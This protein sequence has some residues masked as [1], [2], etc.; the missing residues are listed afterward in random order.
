MNLLGLNDIIFANVSR[1]PDGNHVRYT[2][3]DAFDY[4][5][6]LIS[7]FFESKLATFRHF[8]WQIQVAF[9]LIVVCI[10][11]IAVVAW[12][13]FCHKKRLKQ[14]HEDL[15]FVNTHLRE[16][17][18]NILISPDDYDLEMVE[19][20]C[21]M[22]IE[23]ILKIPSEVLATVISELRLQ[24][25]EVT[26]LPNLDRLCEITG[27]K[28]FY[29]RNLVE[30]RDVLTTLQN[31]VTMTIRISEGHLAT[32]INH[33][34]TNI[35]HMARMC[36]IVCTKAEPYRYLEEDLQEKQALWR[37]MML[38]RLFGWLKDTNRQM[39]QFL[40]LASIINDDATA[41][42][43]IEEIAYWGNEKEKV[44]ISEF[45]LSPKFKC[46]EAALKVVTFLH[47]D[48]QEDAII[49]SYSDQPEYLRREC[50]KAI[51]A[52]NSGKH[53]DFFV[54]SYYDTSS[55]ETR[56]CALSCLY[57]YGIDGRR[58][59]ETMRKDIASD[60]QGINLI[61]QI[62]SYAVLQQMRSI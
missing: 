24:L 50:L 62:D 49:R 54:E 25:S 32:Y 36:Y 4:Y 20:E 52:I 35:R 30:R 9:G 7:Y 3:L 10:I 18:Y 6:G 23:D 28:G 55:K 8:P 1:Y 34:N 45:F 40:V 58:R 14:F 42:F 53:T 60:E 21:E 37:P 19:R 31:L 44:S 27:V 15:D 5:Y 16:H 48:R 29:E 33:H 46:R 2:G 61:N 11:V 38:H 17:F 57:S 12:R 22:S 13:F 59:F 47:D 39:P 51:R 26:V 41:A 43:L 56:E